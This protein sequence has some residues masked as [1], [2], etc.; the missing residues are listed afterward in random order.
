MCI[1]LKNTKRLL[2]SGVNGPYGH[3][4]SRPEEVEAEAVNRACILSN[5]VLL[6]LP[7]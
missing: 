4:L 7:F 6:F 1:L 2:K 5:Q 3:A